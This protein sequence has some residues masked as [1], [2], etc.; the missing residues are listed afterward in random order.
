MILTGNLFEQR[1]HQ[2]NHFVLQLT[3]EMI[4]LLR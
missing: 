3:K 2:F 1:V 4:E